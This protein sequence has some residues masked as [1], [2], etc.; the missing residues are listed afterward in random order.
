MTSSSSTTRIDAAVRDDMSDEP[1]LRLNRGW[2]RRCR[3]FPRPDREG[4]AERR[5]L[6]DLGFDRDSTAVLLD[7]PANDEEPE[8]GTVLL[9]RKI[10]AKE[11]RAVGRVDAGAVVGDRQHNVLP[12]GRGG[13]DDSP[14]LPC[15]IDRVQ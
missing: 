9:G 8:P 14:A 10:R 2:D 15:G 3:V 1:P 6:P 13:H 7:D 5:A 4:D 11:P 12:F